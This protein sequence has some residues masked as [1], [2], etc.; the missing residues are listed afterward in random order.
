MRLSR[1]AASHPAIA[2]AASEASLVAGDRAHT[3]PA[4]MLVDQMTAEEW[5]AVLSALKAQAGSRTLKVT[6]ALPAQAAPLQT[7]QKPPGAK[8]WQEQVA[9]ELLPESTPVVLSGGG[10][11]APTWVCATR[12]ES[13]TRLEAACRA[14]GVQLAAVEPA[15]FALL[16][17][18]PAPPGRA[19]LVVAAVSESG[20]EIAA[21]QSGAPVLARSVA[22]RRRED[23][24]HEL[25]LTVQYLQREGR[26]DITLV[27]AGPAAQAIDTALQARGIAAAATLPFPSA[28]AA[29]A[30]GAS[31]RTRG[32][33]FL[34][35]L[36]GRKP[37]PAQAA[38]A[39]AAV[40]FAACLAYT[41][42]QASVVASLRERV[43]ALQ[44][45]QQALQSQ[46]ERWTGPRAT[47]ARQALQALQ[48]RRLQLGFL[49][50]LGDLVPADLWVEQLQAR[51]G[52][53][54][55]EGHALSRDS[56]LRFAQDV[57]SVWPAATLRIADRDENPMPYYRFVLEVA[58]GP[59]PMPPA[60]P[61]VRQP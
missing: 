42:N 12:R 45:E 41:V 1:K 43:A 55:I 2:L 24:A 47:A 14:C 25:E 11:E 8:G 58:G 18:H 28:A 37:G 22:A 3:V 50:R 21:A 30:T 9:S 39:V 26:Q 52:T 36:P 51:P 40:G 6:V 34:R 27:L 35:E 17:L 29:V 32:P 48:A 49:D 5:E 31:R 16:R 38:A 60:P 13:L 7:V 59:A 33:D 4:P 53:V 56:V 10:R 57:R 19:T 23:V 44:T 15:A 46:L 61:G 54:R 20:C